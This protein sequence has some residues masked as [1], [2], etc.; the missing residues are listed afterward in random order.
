MEVNDSCRRQEAGCEGQLQARG[1][2][3]GVIGFLKGAI[4]L[5]LKGFGFPF[6][7]VS[8]FL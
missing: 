5:L 8:G 4:G 6:K 7:G 3:E 1:F 2:F